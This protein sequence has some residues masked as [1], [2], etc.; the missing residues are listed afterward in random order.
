MNSQAKSDKESVCKFLKKVNSDLSA[1]I[2]EMKSDFER[3][4]PEASCIKDRLMVLWR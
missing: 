4:T 1:V 2:A 3:N